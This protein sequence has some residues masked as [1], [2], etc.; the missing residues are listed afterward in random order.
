MNHKLGPDSF[1]IVDDNPDDV[2]AVRRCLKQARIGNPLAHAESGEE[3]LQLLAAAAAE[4][5]LPALV[6]LDI[7]MPGMKGGEVLLEIRNQLGLPQLPVLMLT[8]SNDDRDVLA[9]FKGK[10]DSYLNK[11]L[12]EDSLRKA[13]ERLRG[14]GVE[15]AVKAAG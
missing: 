13:L 3:A 7:N 10:A 6:L 1:L 15:V 9:A 12:D 5:Q 14:Q 4:G 11:P 2:L 8:S